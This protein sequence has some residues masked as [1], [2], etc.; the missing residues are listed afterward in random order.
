[1]FRGIVV[2]SGATSSVEQ[3]APHVEQVQ[4]YALVFPNKQSSDRK[5]MQ[6]WVDNAGWQTKKERDKRYSFSPQQQ[7]RAT[8]SKDAEGIE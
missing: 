2:D 1:M 3:V 5:C 4:L 8:G 6:Q 7:Y